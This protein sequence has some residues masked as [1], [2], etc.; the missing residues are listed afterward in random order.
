MIVEASS[1]M[2]LIPFP[3]QGLCSDVQRC[4]LHVHD[5]NTFAAVLAC[6]GGIL[7]VRLLQE[8][9]DRLISSLAH[10]PTYPSFLETHVTFIRS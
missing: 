6:D 3:D 4:H 8:D 10:L 1:A 9:H 5:L 7:E 2:R